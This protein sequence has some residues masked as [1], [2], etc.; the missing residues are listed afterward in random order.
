MVRLLFRLKI[1]VVNIFSS[2]CTAK[3]SFLTSLAPVFNGEFGKGLCIPMKSRLFAMSAVKSRCH[4]LSI[5]TFFSRVYFV[6]LSNDQSH[7]K[8]GDLFYRL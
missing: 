7:V 2:V 3:K 1:V 5:V 6:M 8:A 4:D